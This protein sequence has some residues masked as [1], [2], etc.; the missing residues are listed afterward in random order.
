MYQRC[1]P[2]LS[3]AGAGGAVPG[4]EVKEA[5]SYVRAAGDREGGR[6]GA[7]QQISSEAWVWSPGVQVKAG[8]TGMDQQIPAEVSEV[9]HARLSASFL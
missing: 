1:G 3:E 2:A 8:E 7:K 6:V 5:L 4:Q 9:R